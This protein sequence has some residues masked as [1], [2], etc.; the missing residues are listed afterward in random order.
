M[1]LHKIARSRRYPAET[2]TDADYVDDLVLL[3]ESML[4][5]M[6]QAADSI[7]FHVN[8]NK[9]LFIY[10][11]RG[12]VFGLLKLVDVLIYL[13]DNISTTETD[14]NV[15]LAKVWTAIDRLSII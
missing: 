14:V 2:T 13:G 8:I 11:K 10:F 12:A 15:P 4:R 1:A 5:S 9:T 6:E 7:D 3:A